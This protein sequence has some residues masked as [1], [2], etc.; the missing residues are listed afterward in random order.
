MVMVAGNSSC[1]PGIGN[2]RS[3]GKGYNVI[4]VGGFDDRNTVSRAD[5]GMYNCS[6]WQGPNSLSGDREKPEIVAPAQ[7][8]QTTKATGPTWFIRGSGTSL[9]A[10]HVTGT[11]AYMI[12]R[13]TRLATR[14]KEVKA[15]MI[16]SSAIDVSMGS[17]DLDGAGA[18]S[19][20]WADDVTRDSFG[21]WGRI[22]YDCTYPQDYLATTLPGLQAGLRTR[23][24]IVWNADPYHFEYNNRPSFNLDLIVKDPTGAV[25][26]PGFGD[27]ADNTYEWIEFITPVSGTY[28]LYLH[29][30]HCNS[31]T[32][33]IAYAYWQFH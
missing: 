9:A 12:W 5:D 30:E 22:P 11:V 31:P 19:T 13:D 23:F 2:V 14:P 20:L 7:D 21:A 6:G 24:A 4:T 25:M 29:R 28:S 8:I 3:P 33:R 17:T 27:S 10:P 32:G 26:A 15:I 18:I 16:A 1:S